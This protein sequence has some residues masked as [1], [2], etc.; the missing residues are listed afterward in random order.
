M[1]ASPSQTAAAAAEHAVPRVL[2]A[3]PDVMPASI[4]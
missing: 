2:T 1:N 4:K 3:Q